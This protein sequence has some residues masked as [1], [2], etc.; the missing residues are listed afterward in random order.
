MANARPWLVT[1][2]AGF[3]GSHVC[4]RLVAD[5][6]D[7]VGIDNLNDY[8]DP[9]LKQRRIDGLRPL[10]GFRFAKVD[11][12]DADALAA[13]FAIAGPE[14]VIHL[15]AQAGVRHSLR[16]PM[17]YVDANVV[18]FM[19]ILEECRAHQVRHLV[20]ASSSS[21]YGA[22]SKTPF[23]VGDP[24]GHP[25]SIYAATKRAN[26]LMAHSYAHLFGLPCTGLR[27][28]T[29]YGP[30]GRP[31]MAYYRFAEAMLAGEP[32]TIYGDGSAIRDFTYIDDI[33]EG[34]VRIANQ[35]AEAEPTWSPS[36]PDQSRS[37]AP[38]R[39]LNIGHGGQATVSE[40]VGLL[41][42]HLGLEARREYAPAQL[43]DLEVTH[44]ETEDL[45]KATGFTPKITLDEG[46]RRFALWVGEYRE[47]IPRRVSQRPP[48]PSQGAGA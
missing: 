17:A 42:R 38:W 14:H 19:R 22:Y 48:H 44:A 2:A 21:V 43:G 11:L 24:T 47:G 30:W 20:Y 45:E 12:T 15:A 39:L 36:S 9:A 3:I 5:G 40:L 8:Y 34:V 33:V 28:F 37:R 25:V 31:D 41:E 18:G 46:I 7:V 29:V 35:P 1:G 4:R 26:E 23:R 10:P 6:H 16:A 32:I 27:F 13:A